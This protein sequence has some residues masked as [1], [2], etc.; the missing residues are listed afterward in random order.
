MRKK[1]KK[2][3]KQS[4]IFNPI[5]RL[6]QNFIFDK[7]Y[8]Q[9]ILN[10][11]LI[12]EN[13]LVIEIGSGYGIFTQLI[14]EKT[15]CH[16]IIS[17]EKDERLFNLL[18]KKK[19]DKI[20]FVLQDALKI[21]WG[22]YGRQLEENRKG[23]SINIVGNLPYNIANS[24]LIE[25]LLFSNFFSSFSF[26]VQEEVARRWLAKPKENNY[27]AISVFINFFS[28]PKIQF[29]VPGT[30]FIPNSAVRG[31]LVTIILKKEFS[32]NKIEIKNF[33]SFLRNCFQF[34]RKTL[35]NNLISFS[36]LIEWK[37]YYF[38]KNYSLNLRPSDL[39]PSEFWELFSFFKKSKVIDNT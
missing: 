25:L 5:K 37:K 15:K 23:K 30:V 34:R 3:E 11:C 20:T 1:T 26:L 19:T 9:K 28:L 10:N 35:F 7:V 12:E 33:W 29:L 17:L 36:N 31:A 4:L 22:T 14:A 6:G 16:D 2:N 32:F 39:S 24:L 27:S 18:V 8:L 13:S 38:W 21:D